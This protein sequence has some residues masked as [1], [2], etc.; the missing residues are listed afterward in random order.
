MSTLLAIS[1]V[2]FTHVSK[3]GTI[4][5]THIQS[6]YA[7]QNDSGRRNDNTGNTRGGIVRHS[8]LWPLPRVQRGSRA[9]HTS[10]I[11]PLPIGET[12]S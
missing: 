8:T 7:E 10:P 2:A 11:P 1:R 9:L 12:I 6:D 5:L 3:R 4:P